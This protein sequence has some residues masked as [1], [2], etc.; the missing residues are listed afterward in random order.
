MLSTNNWRQKNAIEMLELMSPFLKQLPIVS[1]NDITYSSYVSC[2]TY[3]IRKQYSVSGYPNLGKGFTNEEA[4]LSGLME[5]L[6]MCCI[7]SLAPLEWYDESIKKLLDKPKKESNKVT[8]N[9]TS[10]IGEGKMLSFEDI[11]FLKG[12]QQTN[13]NKKLTNGLASGQYLEDAL[14]HSIYELIER[15]M[16]G[17]SIYT[18]LENNE[19]SPLVQQFI[20]QLDD[21]GLKCSIYLRG[22]YAD[23]VTIEAHIIDNSLKYMP[24]KVGAI[25]F[26]C[27]G[28]S[29]VAIARAISEAFQSLSVAKSV[30]NKSYGLGTHL[31]DTSYGYFDELNKFYEAS[32]MLAKYIL[33]TDFNNN[34]MEKQQI[35]TFSHVHNCDE[36]IRE[37]KKEGINE[38]NYLLITSKELPFVV[39]R[40]FINQLSNSYGI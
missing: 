17:S 8:I 23:T 19:V 15:H 35:L 25:G 20:S 1:T 34:S 10:L 16:I 29:E 12:S 3:E 13:Y 36:L 2:F 18:K 9:P 14:V 37:L 31:T 5:S 26:G 30:N 7:E 21:N 38:L 6:E 22:I 39:T 33:K 4:K 11:F 28:D 24:K 32:I 27:S 40:C